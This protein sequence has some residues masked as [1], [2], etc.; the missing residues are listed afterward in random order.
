MTLE[1]KEM[2]KLSRC[3]C[4]LDFKRGFSSINKP[5]VPWRATRK[6]FDALPFPLAFLHRW[7]WPPGSAQS[8][9]RSGSHAAHHMT[10]LHS[11]TPSTPVSQNWNILNSI[12]SIEIYS[13]WFKDIEWSCNERLTACFKLGFADCRHPQLHSLEG[14]L[15]RLQGSLGAL[16]QALGVVLQSSSLKLRHLHD[17]CITSAQSWP[18]WQYPSTSHRF[19]QIPLDMFRDVSR[20]C[21]MLQDAAR[22]YKLLHG[23]GN[24]CL[25]RQDQI[26][27]QLPSVL[28]PKQY[29][30]SMAS[31]SQFRWGQHP[32]L[33]LKL[34][35]I[36]TYSNNFKH[37]HSSA[38]FSRFQL[39]NQSCKP[40]C[41]DSFA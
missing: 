21:K 33:S 14:F 6:P 38:M 19:G 22:L 34:K 30:T 32:S 39:Q 29:Q 10:Q 41:V 2:T 1:T 26:L 36:Q 4:I 5:V 40:S 12:E 25:W 7:I 20:C 28:G 27:S 18:Y 31:P 24:V 35:T 3:C 8:C 13:K 15:R 37:T 9:T 23:E 17:I 16:G 11:A